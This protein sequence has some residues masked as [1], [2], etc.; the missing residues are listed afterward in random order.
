MNNGSTSRSEHRAMTNCDIVATR[1][2]RTAIYSICA[3]VMLLLV[4]RADLCAEQPADRPTVEELTKVLQKKAFIKHKNSTLI[5]MNV[6]K[7]QLDA[8]AELRKMGT[9]A[10]AATPALVKLVQT[11]YAPIQPSAMSALAAV[12]SPPDRAVE[13]LIDKAK[14]DLDVLAEVALDSLAQMGDRASKA[15]PFLAELMK[16]PNS[17]TAA[18]RSAMQAIE[19]FKGGVKPYA[20][21]FAHV[22]RTGDNYTASWAAGTLCELKKE[23][24]SLTPA[25]IAHTMARHADKSLFVMPAMLASKVDPNGNA[26]IEA[27]KGMLLTSKS[28][29][30]RTSAAQAMARY[31]GSKGRDILLQFFSHRDKEIRR[32]A[33]AG[34]GVRSWGW[35]TKESVALL[36]LA[37]G[38]RSEMVRKAAQT[39]LLGMSIEQK[40]FQK[41]LLSYARSDSA[42]TRLASLRLMGK[43]SKLLPLKSRVSVI[44]NGLDDAD[45]EVVLMAIAM[46]KE[47]PEHANAFTP[48]LKRLAEGSKSTVRKQA[49]AVLQA[50]N[51]TK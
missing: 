44:T 3:L 20:E 21:S 23:D 9:D 26:V 36:H 47:Y 31:G 12:A 34:F 15:G 7:Q 45:E 42:Q 14:G 37:T 5:E 11:G 50:L 51:D 4:A 43:Q 8:L 13:A 46:C 1:R 18:I 33:A 32:A 48:G 40:S 10:N 17:S 24:I 35:S 19:S 49:A 25:D 29:K 38:D 16:D 30:A 27:L 2:P 6:F 41:A 22:L 39:A 28:A